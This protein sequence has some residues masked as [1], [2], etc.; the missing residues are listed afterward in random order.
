MPVGEPSVE[1]RLD[2]L[3]PYAELVENGTSDEQYFRIFEIAN[4]DGF[5]P[6]WAD[7]PLFLSTDPTLIGQWVA[8]LLQR[9]R[10]ATLAV[11]PAEPKS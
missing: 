1:I 11:D 2:E 7:H 6:R 8:L 9:A 5:A 10:D 3:Y 4:R